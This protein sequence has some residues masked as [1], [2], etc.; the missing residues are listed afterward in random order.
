MLLILLTKQAE[1]RSADATLTSPPKEKG[2][3]GGKIWHLNME[4]SRN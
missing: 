2:V 1:K 3:Y 4:Y